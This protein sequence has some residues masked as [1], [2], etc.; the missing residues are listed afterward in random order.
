MRIFMNGIAGWLQ[1][2]VIEI[3]G[4]LA[5]LWAL[6]NFTG[7]NVVLPVTPAETVTSQSVSATCKCDV[8]QNYDLLVATVFGD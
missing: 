2:A 8:Q 4:L 3:L 7:S 1:A 6:A 5:L